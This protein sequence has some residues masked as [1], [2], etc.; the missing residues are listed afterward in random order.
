M[1]RL[2]FDA[3]VHARTGTVFQPRNTGEGIGCLVG[4]LRYRQTAPERDRGQKLLVEVSDAFL[5]R[6]HNLAELPAANVYSAREG[7]GMEIAMRR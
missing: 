3:H 1:T 4:H 2:R 6:G 7:V 5:G